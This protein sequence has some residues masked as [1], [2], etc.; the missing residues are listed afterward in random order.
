MNTMFKCKRKLLPY[1][2][3]DRADSLKGDGQ[4]RKQMIDYL[5]KKRKY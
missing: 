3:I 2:I 1:E 5:L 4:K